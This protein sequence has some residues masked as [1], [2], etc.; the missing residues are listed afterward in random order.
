MKVRNISNNTTEV[1]LAAMEDITIS[2]S[3]DDP[4]DPGEFGFLLSLMLKYLRALGMKEGTIFMKERQR[5]VN[6]RKGI[7]E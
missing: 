4:D 1:T 5:K 7:T 2:S 6:P 3:E